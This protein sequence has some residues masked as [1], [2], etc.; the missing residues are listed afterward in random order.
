[1][2]PRATD[3][4]GRP[5]DPGAGIVPI[6]KEISKGRLAVV[7]T[8]FYITRYGLFLTAQHVLESLAD[9]TKQVVQPGY[10]CHLAENSIVHLRRIL[11]VSLLQPADLAIGQA[12]NYLSKYPDDPL[13]N[14]RATLSTD[15]PDPGSR[16]I[17]YAYPKNEVLDF[18][19][20]EHTPVIKSDYFEGVFLRYMTNSEN[21]FMLYPHFETSIELKSGASG[22]PVFDSRGRVVGVNCRGWDFGGGEHEGNNLSSI[23]PVKEVL[24][25]GLDLL[26][27]PPNSWEYARIPAHRKGKT[28]TVA[29]LAR[30]RHIDFDPPVM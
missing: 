12:D 7:G 30:F 13:M 10:V 15:I 5:I 21:P 28:F 17:T 8:G 18:T 2:R 26:Q 22:G 19:R 4:D 11:R 14:M 6:M 23:V 27:L 9:K 1:M 24:T 3:G 20:E 16:V 29:E 25:L